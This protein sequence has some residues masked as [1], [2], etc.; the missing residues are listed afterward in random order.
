MSWAIGFDSNWNRDIGYGVP[1][2]CDHPKCKA[3]IDRGLSYV[4]GGDAYGGDH[5]CG[6]FFCSEHLSYGRHRVQLCSRCY[7]RK[8]PFIA[9]PD[10]PRWI[11]HKATDDS[12]A[13]WRSEQPKAHVEA[14][15]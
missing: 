10:H 8:P 2:F 1:A 4:C 3:E 15:R 6:L 14:S 9:K 12:W 13:Q 7:Y 5:G 11:E